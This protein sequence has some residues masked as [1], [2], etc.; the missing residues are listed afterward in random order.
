LCSLKN[1]LTAISL[2]FLSNS[3]RLCLAMY[4]NSRWQL[5]TEFRSF[6]SRLILAFWA[7]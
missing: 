3:G 6:F 5:S 4:K 7:E 1:L 2:I